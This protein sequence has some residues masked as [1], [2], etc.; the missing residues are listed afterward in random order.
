VNPRDID[1][2]KT[3]DQYFAF[4]E[5]VTDKFDRQIDVKK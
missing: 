3:L 5:T 2:E 1:V 4:V